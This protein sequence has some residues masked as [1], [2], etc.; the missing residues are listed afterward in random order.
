MADFAAA[1]DVLSTRPELLITELKLGAFNGLHLAIR[2]GVQGTPAIVVGDPD[3][4]LEAEAKRQQA[5]YLSPPL[6]P[7]RVL[8]V[9]G[10]LL[11]AALRTRRSPRKQ[12][13][14]LDAFANDVPARVLDV[15]YEGMRIE[16]VETKSEGLPPVFKV[17]LPLFNFSC[18]VQRVWTS[19]L[20][21]T[22]AQAPG[23][24][25]GAMLAM[26]NDDTALAWRTLVDA[27]P[28]LAVT[29]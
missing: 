19:P 27:L 23:I 5:T 22:G 25:V 7:E 24:S 21:A 11:A 13:P 26:A 8:T 14:Q 4:V 3:P 16:S 29:N 18:D 1:K 9:V 17:R 2:A 6:D 15:S 10:E 20:T 28:G 12:V